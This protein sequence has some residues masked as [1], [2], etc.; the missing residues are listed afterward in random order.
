MFNR[1]RFIVALM[2]AV[3]L[4]LAAL[5]V[6][7]VEPTASPGLAAYMTPETLALVLGALW[8]LSELLA[9]IPGVKA[10]GV[11]HAVQLFLAKMLGKE[12]V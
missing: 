10:N 7:A 1:I 4:C 3:I 6:A 12:V 11:F 9:V 8:S 5:A 2:L